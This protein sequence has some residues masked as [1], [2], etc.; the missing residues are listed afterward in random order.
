MPLDELLGTQHGVFARG[1][2]AG[3]V[4]SWALLI[5]LT[6]CVE[7]GALTVGDAGTGQDAAVVVDSVGAD[8]GQ[9]PDAP[10]ADGAE[11]DSS[12]AD[13]TTIDSRAEDAIAVV[14]ATPADSQMADDS[15]P[16][17]LAYEEIDGRLVIEA[18]HFD[19]KRTNGTA[20]AWYL[21]S[22]SHTP[23][24]TPD[25]DSSHASTAVGHAYLEGLPDTRVKHDDRM[26]SG[27]NFFGTPGDG[28]VVTYRAY[29][30]TSGRYYV[31]V[32][33]YSTGTE[34]NG[35]H[36][37]LD[38]SWPASGAR[39]Q[40]CAGKNNWTWSGAQRTEAEHCGVENQIFLDVASSGEHAIAFSM[41]EDGFEFDR[42]VLTKDS[43]YMPAGTGPA[44]SPTR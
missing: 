11:A 13:S 38:G 31:R 14:D 32:R 16:V 3:A 25:P 5:G 34:D 28:P 27:V 33:A 17:V 10:L 26:Q 41:R 39:I 37:G 44:E 42:F 40:W 8:R 2:V 19:V 36:V 4:A 15:G 29:F 21:T 7:S 6:A 12:I 43:G 9:H 1:R 18:E 20:R 23:G 30:N 22:T 24:I 35:V